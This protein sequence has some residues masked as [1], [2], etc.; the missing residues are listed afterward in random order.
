[1]QERTTMTF[2]SQCIEQLGFNTVFKAFFGGAVGALLIVGAFCY[3]LGRD[4]ATWQ[5]I[6]IASIGACLGV[7]GAWRTIFLTRH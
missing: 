4:F 1:M 7:W 2:I 6:I 3:V 5:Q